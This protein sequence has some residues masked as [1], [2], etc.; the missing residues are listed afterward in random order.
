MRVGSAGTTKTVREDR[1]AEDASSP[2]SGF[3]DLFQGTRPPESS[4]GDCVS[5]SVLIPQNSK[6][7]TRT[8]LP[9]EG[10]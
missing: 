10:L 1:L 4:G 6:I 2:V 9:E 7:D 8:V 3:L 5:A